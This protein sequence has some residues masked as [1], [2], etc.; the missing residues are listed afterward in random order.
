M[1]R[2]LEILIYLSN[3]TAAITEGAK[4]A[5]EKWPVGN[6]FKSGVGTVP[7]VSVHE[8]QIKSDQ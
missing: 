5:H 3:A 2:V 6:P 8:Q 7:N 4:V 1:K